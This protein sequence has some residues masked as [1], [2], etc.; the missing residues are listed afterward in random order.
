MFELPVFG[1]NLIHLREVD[2]T[3][4]LAQA[5]AKEGEPEGTVV[6]ADFQAQ[7][8]GQGGKHWESEPGQNLTFSLILRPVFLPPAEAGSLSQAVALSVHELV[9]ELIESTDVRIKWP[10]DILVEHKKICGILIENQLEGQKLKS[11]IVGIGLNVNQLF[12]G[13]GLNYPPTSLALGKGHP[14]EVKAVLTRLLSIL[15]KN[16]FLLYQGATN[17]LREEFEAH[18]WGK[19]TQLPAIVMGERGLGEIMGV[20]SDGRLLMKWKGTIRVFDLQ[21]VKFMPIS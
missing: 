10:N 17:R 16:Y 6:V 9:S 4:R 12:F 21:E 7:G 18:L 2:S 8:R 5:Y 20:H 11:T 1:K 14:F 13:D 19:G 15:S 3:N